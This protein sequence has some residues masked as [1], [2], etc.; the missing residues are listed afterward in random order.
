MKSLG[1]L[2]LLCCFT[3]FSLSQVP[4]QILRSLNRASDQWL[5]EITE[6]DLNTKLDTNHCSSFL[7]QEN[8]LTKLEFGI[9]N[10][11]CSTLLEIRALSELY[12]PLFE[13][14][15]ESLGLNDDCLLYTSPSPRDQRGSR[16]PSSA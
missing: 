13:K 11:Y 8:A 12:F 3:I 16:M 14:K 7:N 2:S 9:V 1:L 15:L 5:L 10:D 6:V 4:D